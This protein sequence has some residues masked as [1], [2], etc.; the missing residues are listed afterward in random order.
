LIYITLIGMPL[1]DYLIAPTNFPRKMEHSRARD[2]KG[3]EGKERE[4]ENKAG[5]RRSP[6]IIIKNQIAT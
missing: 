1:F 5:S 4:R 6:G 3:D 2:G